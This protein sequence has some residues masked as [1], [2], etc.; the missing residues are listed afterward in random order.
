MNV[1]MDVL[2]RFSYNVR[3]IPEDEVLLSEALSRR[4]YRTGLVGKWHLGGT[5]GFLP[6]DRG[7]DSFYGALWSN[8]DPPYAIYRDRQV[9]KEVDTGPEGLKKVKE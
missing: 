6:N 7:F 8:D 2:G 9:L 1:L 3:G 4:G 5:P